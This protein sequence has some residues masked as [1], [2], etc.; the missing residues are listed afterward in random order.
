MDTS[1]TTNQCRLHYISQRVSRLKCLNKS[2]HNDFVLFATG[3]N[4]SNN[5][6]SLW[7]VDIKGQTDEPLEISYFPN[8][9]GGVISDLRFVE[10]RSQP[11]I[12][13]S[14]SK[15]SLTVIKPNSIPKKY[16]EV[17]HRG[18]H[19]QQNNTSLDMPEEP[20]CKLEKVKRWENLHKG[21]ITAIDTTYD[22]EHIVTVGNDGVLNVLSIDS[23][24]PIYTNKKIDG[25]SVHTVRYMTNN[26]IITSGVNS[27]LKF[28]DIRSST[29]Q[30]IKTIRQVQQTQTSP[31]HSIAVHHDQTHIIATG[32]AD[33]YVS[34]FDFRN[35]FAIDQNQNHKSHV[36]E[37]EFSKSKS[38]QLFSCSQDGSVY[39]YDYNRDNNM[40]ST[41]I[42]DLYDKAVTPVVA[43][44]LT[45]S[46]IDS[47][48]ISAHHLFCVGSSQSLVI[49]S[50][51][52]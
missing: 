13:A 3:S 15:G 52:N 27:V 48:D 26:E 28:W 37:V 21:G 7:G 19:S 17:Q 44:G 35:S 24:I 2:Y 6:I 23:P 9:G 16:T 49:K 25:L 31:T 18:R 29:H 34:L 11:A 32:N 43:S 12:V 50:L 5:R 41:N 46:S 8:G 30:P 36:W 1:I 39:L 22:N 51:I 38:N 4:Q 40:T 47:F 42:F 33:G 14:D 10:M 20:S 45:A